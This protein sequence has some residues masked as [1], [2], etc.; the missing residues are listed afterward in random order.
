MKRLRFNA[1]VLTAGAWVFA[2]AALA[3]KTE[4][5][6]GEGVPA[7][8]PVPAKIT[9]DAYIFPGWYRD[10]GRGDHPYRTHDEDSEWHTYR[11]T[12]EVEGTWSGTLRTLRFDFGS[13]GDTILIDWIRIDAK[14]QKP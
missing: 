6:R 7:P 5:F 4:T 8:N 13:V 11:I 3:Q 12:K 1:A 9:L 14:A 2:S 10:T